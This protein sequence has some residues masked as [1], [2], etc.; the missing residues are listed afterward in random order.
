MKRLLACVV[1]TLACSGTTGGRLLHL[2]F[3][4]SGHTPSTFTTPGGWTVSLTRARVALGP[5]YLN[6]SPP[7]TNAFRGGIVLMEATTQ[8]VMD[9]LDP[10]EHELGDGVDGQSGHAVAAEIGLLPADTTQAA[11]NI[12]LLDGAVAY[13]EGTATRGTD[14]LPF[15]GRV[16]LDASLAT[17]TVSLA[18]LQRIP[19]AATDLSFQSNDQALSLAVDA[20]HWFDQTD[21]GLLLA[22][23]PVDGR[24]TWEQHSTFHS[25]LFQGLRTSSGV[26]SWSLWTR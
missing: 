21:F 25:Q 23:V 22:T 18:S 24:Y 9:P 6:V 20:T 2:P 10:S 1:L 11:E 3:R 5:F 4:I 19:G 16:L 26:Y 14:T 13:V 17:D 12:T 8:L 7:P 15:A